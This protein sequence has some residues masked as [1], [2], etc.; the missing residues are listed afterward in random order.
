MGTVVKAY[1]ITGHISADACRTEA[2]AQVAAGGDR[3]AMHYHSPEHPCGDRCEAAVPAS[4]TAG[5][6]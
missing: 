6:T 1:Y 2:A 3:P 5:P 4:D